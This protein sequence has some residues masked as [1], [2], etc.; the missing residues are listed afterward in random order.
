M[1]RAWT[2]AL[3]RLIRLMRSSIREAAISSVIESTFAAV[4]VARGCS[5]CCLAVW[6]CRQLTSCKPSYVSVC[7]HLSA[8]GA[9]AA[10]WRRAA[11][12]IM[13]GA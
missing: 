7:A 9:Y 10:V 12:R 3:A 11:A 13:K 6:Q 1:S 8:E 5:C 4:I 2:F